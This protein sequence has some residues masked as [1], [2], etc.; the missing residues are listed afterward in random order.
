MNGEAVEG[1]TNGD[2]ESS[3]DHLEEH[4]VV[5]KTLAPVDSECEEKLGEAHV[6]CEGNDVYDALLTQ[7][8]T[9][10]SNSKHSPA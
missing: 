2:S 7:T 1:G 3:A 6:C 5:M 8:C 9:Q 10:N 4:T